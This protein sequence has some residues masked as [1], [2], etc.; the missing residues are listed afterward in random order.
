MFDHTRAALHLLVKDLKKIGFGLSVFTQLVTITYLVY[1]LAAQKGVVIANAIMLTITAA[2][3]LFFLYAESK[4][5]QKKTKRRVSAMY[6]WGKRLTKLLTICIVAYGL[7]V[8]GSD[9]SPFSFF[10]LVMMI[11][12]WLL[13]LLFYIIEKYVAAKIQLLW[14]GIVS[15]TKP[16]LKVVD[17]VEKFKNHKGIDME[18]SEEHAVALHETKTE[19]QEKK[20]AQKKKDR[21]AVWQN[22]KALFRKNNAEEKDEDAIDPDV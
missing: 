22:F 6:K 17:F 3:L 11:V 13:N 20:K 18:V 14:S 10:L 5:L 15:D 1:N 4:S 21:E 2:Y 12:G 8:S 16:V 7:V 9:F 19:L